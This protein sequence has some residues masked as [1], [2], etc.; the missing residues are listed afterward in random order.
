MRKKQ[1]VDIRKRGLK[2]HNKK[3]HEKLKIFGINSA[4]I[5]CKVKSFDNVLQLLKPHIWML[6]ETKLRPHEKINCGSLDDY[7][8]FY[9]S[10]QESHGGGLALGVHK[11]LESTFLKEGDDETEAISVLV[12]VGDIPIRIIVGYGV[13]ENASKQSKEM[14]WEFIEKEVNQ[15]E[16]ENQA[17]IIQMDGNLHAGNYLVKNDPNPQNQNGR[18]F[19]Q[20]LRRNPSLT[21]VNSL[22]MCEGTITRIRELES[23]TETA[24]LDFFIVNEKLSP[25]LKRMVVDENRDFILSNFD[26]AK[27]NKRIIESDHNGLILEIDI[28]FSHKKP[29]RL[30]MFNLKNIECQKAFKTVSYTHLTLPTILLV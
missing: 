17:V 13:Q 26:Q 23:R 10:R 27:K 8:V 6:Q 21:V 1:N 3:Q 22:S 29:E 16:L 19:M 7:Q 14:F 12:T 24:V 20:F 5:R 11:M 25:F 18:L 4:G 9:L 2:R 30:E 15:A 28:Q